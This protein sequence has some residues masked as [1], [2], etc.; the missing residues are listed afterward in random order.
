MMTTRIGIR[1]RTSQAPSVNLTE[2]TTTATAP[3]STAPKALMARRRRQ[4]GDRSRSQ[5]RTMPVWLMVK[6][7]N[8]PT[9]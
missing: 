3:V 9:A 5:C 7:M 4:P 2:V 8:T 1:T 6:S